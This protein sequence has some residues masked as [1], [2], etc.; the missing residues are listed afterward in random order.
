MKD[1]KIV[2][3]LKKSLAGKLSLEEKELLDH[4]LGHSEANRK[5][6]KEIQ[7]N[8]LLSEQIALFQEANWREA[9]ERFAIQLQK[10]EQSRKAKL[11]AV[12]KKMAAAAV[13]VSVIALGV[14]FLNKPDRKV[15]SISKTISDTSQVDILP[16]VEGA[17]LTLDDGTIVQLDGNQQNQLLAKQG[18]KSIVNN[19][20]E[21]TYSPGIENDKNLMM[22]TVQTGTGGMYKLVLADGT[23][24]ILNSKSS[25]RFPVNFS[26]GERKVELIGQAYFEVAEDK[27]S[28]FIVKSN[29]TH[30]KV[31]GTKFD[32]NAYITSRSINTTTL[33]EGSIMIF[34]D[35]DQ[36]FLRPNQQALIGV[37]KQIQ[38]GNVTDTKSVIAWTKGK[39]S[40]NKAPVEE[41]FEELKRNYPIKN[42]RYEGVIDSRFSGEVPKDVPLSEVL[43]V[44][45]MTG[46]IHFKI[47]GDNEIV[48]TP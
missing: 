4:W 13:L 12:F 43:K 17:Q 39:F 3:I 25:L 31:L 2:P 10:E 40:F 1:L 24:V 19:R 7:D 44:F 5:F 8:E 16:I 38:I 36:K 22:N 45:S 14:F 32:I 37:G 23:K 41:I 27:K 33:L 21:L 46:L 48:V 20:K 9:Y 26:F 6:F 18:R 35:Q 29:N 47:E 42:V 34:H 11:V 15:S 30:I 28:P